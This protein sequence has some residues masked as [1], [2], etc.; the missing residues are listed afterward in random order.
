L[1]KNF[2]PESTASGRESTADLLGAADGLGYAW[3]DWNMFFLLKGANTMKLVPMSDTEYADYIAVLIPDYAADHVRAGN[4]AADEA[5]AKAA[6]QVKELLPDG[7]RTPDQYLYT[8][9]VDE[10]QE[11]VG[12]IWLAVMRQ[13]LHPRAFIYD[14]LIYENFRRRGYATQ[15]LRAIE[16]KASE[17]GAT[18]IALH[19]FGHNDGARTL[20]EKVGYVVTDY[21]MAKDL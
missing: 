21:V 1:T 12:I 8:L 19:V 11:P 3:L 4:W 6:A 14:I 5:E 2:A 17:L 15:G 10:E 18:S 20:Y 16:E 7:P 9:H 13:G